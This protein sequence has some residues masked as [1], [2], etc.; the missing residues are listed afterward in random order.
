MAERIE[1]LSV[2][3]P[4]IVRYFERKNPQAI[5]RWDQLGNDEYAR[6][7]TAAR[8]AGNDIV[9]DLYF[10]LVDNIERG[11]TNRDYAAAVLP[12]LR[13]KGW[14]GGDE[15]KLAS[16][17][18][19]IYDTNINLARGAGLWDR[20]QRNAAITPYLLAVTARDRRV[21]HPP[22]SPADHRAWDGICLP[23]NHPF[24][25]RWWPPLGFR[26]RCSIIPLSRS[27]YARRGSPLTSAGELAD[28]EARLGKPVFLAPGAGIMAQLNQATEASNAAP[29]M[30]GLPIVNP[31]EERRAAVNAWQAAVSGALIEALLAQIIGG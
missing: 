31:V 23:V 28:R 3:A 13:Q 12:T 24:W 6:S 4:D 18:Q 27:Q 17:V 26:C 19:L 2:S 5:D 10:A 11:G 25:T 16:R 1:P 15:G 30:S 8:T 20:V 29:R 9:D 14:L 22:K 7:F 21:R